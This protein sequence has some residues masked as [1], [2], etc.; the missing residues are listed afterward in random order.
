MSYMFLLRV[1]H[2][3]ASF[4]RTRFIMIQCI[5]LFSILQYFSCLIHKLD[6]GKYSLHSASQG[7]TKCRIPILLLATAI[8]NFY[9]GRRNIRRAEGT[10]IWCKQFNIRC[11]SLHRYLLPVHAKICNLSPEVHWEWATGEIPPSKAC[12]QG[13]FAT[14]QV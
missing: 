9:K 7:E 13:R 11:K 6:F 10:E 12:Q 4:L 3:K 8:D 2:Y 5:I 1:S 14:Q